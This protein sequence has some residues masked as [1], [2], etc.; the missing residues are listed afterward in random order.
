M[1]LTI[2]ILND[3]SIK[4]IVC[5]NTSV[6]YKI[7]D[8]INFMNQELDQLRLEV[9][10]VEHRIT[11]LGYPI[12]NDIVYAMKLGIDDAVDKEA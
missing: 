5:D 4:P 1:I 2:K 6:S 12:Q 8:I 10:D 7:G 3:E 11:D 9:T